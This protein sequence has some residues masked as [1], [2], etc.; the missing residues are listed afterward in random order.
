MKA[1]LAVFGVLL[2]AGCVRVPEGTVREQ[3]AEAFSC[4]HYALTV[5]EVGPD[6][7][8]ATGCGQ[9]LIY[10]CQSTR[11]NARS[12]EPMVVCARTPE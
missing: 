9:E 5:V 6:L 10:A 7:Y 12:E 1:G 11:P 4:A 8:R 2:S 3:A